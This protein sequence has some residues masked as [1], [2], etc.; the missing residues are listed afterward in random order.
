MQLIGSEKVKKNLSQWFQWEW[1]QSE[2]RE[3]KSPVFQPRNGTDWPKS[4]FNICNKYTLLPAVK[5]NS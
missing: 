2:E 5:F 4:T 3:K 1:L